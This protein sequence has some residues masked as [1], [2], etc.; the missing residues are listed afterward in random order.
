MT[1]QTALSLAASIVGF[2]AAIFFCIGN[3]S[4]SIEKIVQQAGTYYSFNESLARA[5]ASQRAQYVIG[6]L[7]LLTSF[8]LQV[9]AT[10]ASSTTPANL[11][12]LLHTWPY[13]ALA[14]FVPIALL[15]W[16]GCRALVEKTIKQVL[17]RNQELLAEEAA[18]E[19]LAKKKNAPSPNP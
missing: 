5:L 7:L 8:A 18:A 15:S 13:L 14:V 12:Q 6:A 1:E 19:A 3:A 11:P 10:V 9:L 16:L 2:V 4:N 17:I